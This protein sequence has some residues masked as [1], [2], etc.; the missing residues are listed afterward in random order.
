MRFF[1]LRNLEKEC[2]LLSLWQNY[3]RKTKGEPELLVYRPVDVEN[4]L[5]PYLQILAK[6]GPK[7]PNH[8]YRMIRE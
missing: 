2:E 3:D 1:A 6:A 4:T 7:G 5:T 8:L